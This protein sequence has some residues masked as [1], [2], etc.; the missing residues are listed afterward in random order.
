MLV[1]VLVA[2]QSASA[3]AADRAF[4]IR[5]SA[6]D[7]GNI[8]IAANTLLTCPA[9]ASGCA[10]AQAGGATNNNSF[11]M[12]YVDVDSDST[13]FDSSQ[14][15]L[16]LPTGAT[17]LF[18]GLYWGGDTSAG[19]AGGVA[20]PAAASRGSVKFAPPGA[21]YSTVTAST[22]DAS[23]ANATRYQGFAN[24]TSMVQAAGAGTYTVANVQAG[25]G[26]D[27]YAGWG[28]VVAYHDPTQPP[29]NLT[30]F[31]GLTT[32]SSANP[33]VDIPVSGFVTPA[34]GPVNT[35]LGF[36]GWEGDRGSTGDSASLNST[37]LTD[38]ANPTSNF[39]NSSIANF[40]VNVSTRN[41]NYVNQLG[42]DADLVNANGILGNSATSAT[43][44]LTTGGETYLPGVVTFAT[45]LF[46]PHLTPA[47]T[48]TDV[49]GGAVEQGDTI[50]YDI[51]ATNT[52]Q[53]SATGVK[54][55]DPIPDH[56]TY[57]PGS[58]Q[59]VSSPGGI[60][61]A[62][63]DATGDDQADGSSAGVTFRVG[64][65]ANA[66]SGGTI[67]PGQSYEV[68]FRVTIDSPTADGTLI[69][70]TASNTYAALSNPGFDLA[71]ASSPPDAAHARLARPGDR[72]D[73]RRRVRERR[74]VVVHARGLE[75]RL[76]RERGPGDGHRHRAGDA[77]GQ[78]PPPA[79]AG[80]AALCPR[81]SRAPARMLSQRARR[82]PAS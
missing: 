28:L 35:S 7:T 66:T 51:S 82:S 81:P 3:G 54:V 12:A 24:V 27:R 4:S 10:A 39:F 48:A 1:I 46:A 9:A 14:S 60:A 70:N 68:R 59:I 71:D 43:I 53:D 52:G 29:R 30:V 15:D 20:A 23:S 58:L 61:G 67:A 72:E 33:T 75:H 57:V 13:T 65:G 62:K 80:R 22:L 6:N 63:T 21:A 17:V 42:Y 31:D 78:R 41:P 16:V 25:T 50:E 32:V 37:K 47:K 40:G 45:E 74:L 55:T 64:T 36:I 5:F 26:Q 73:R 38:A 77:P 18:A 2:L 44:H 34:S 69:Q 8:T 49:N 76:E 19:A 56:T 11:T 79:R